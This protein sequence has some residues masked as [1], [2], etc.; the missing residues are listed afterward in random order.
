MF[1]I[2]KPNLSKKKFSFK[3]LE[4]FYDFFL[5][6]HFLKNCE[7]EK[8]STLTRHISK[9]RKDLE[10]PLHILILY[11]AS[12]VQTENN[13]KIFSLFQDSKIRREI[14]LDFFLF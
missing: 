11:D 8:F 2:S 3:E 12:N 9:V 13:Q 4:K 10:L 6:A 7:N 14:A 5:S 1:H